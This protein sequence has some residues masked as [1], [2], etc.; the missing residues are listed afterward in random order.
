MKV[1]SVVSNPAATIDG[2]NAFAPGRI[3]NWMLFSLQSWIK[4]FPGS[5]NHGVHASEITM[6]SFSDNNLA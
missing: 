6:A 3:V 4:D 1:N 5:D 2:T